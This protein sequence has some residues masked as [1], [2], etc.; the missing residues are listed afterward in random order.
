MSIPV[1]QLDRERPYP[2]RVTTFTQVFWDGLRDGRF[3]ITRCRA[4]GRPSFPPREFCPGCWSREVEWI[5]HDGGG[6]LYSYTVVHAAPGAFAAEVPYRLG[7]VDLKD[8]PRL[9]TRLLGDGP[10]PLDRPVQ[11]VVLLYRDGPL[12][13]AR[14]SP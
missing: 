8:G 6:R 13:A 9:A 11:L 4:C 7:I 10:A 3:R 12:F 5:D 2:P 1:L 14:L